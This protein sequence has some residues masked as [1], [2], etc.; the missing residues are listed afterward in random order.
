[1]FRGKPPG[2]AAVDRLGSSDAG[3]AVL[4]FLGPADA[5]PDRALRH[6]LPC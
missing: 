4:G 6:G 1:M 3:M 5:R 2:P